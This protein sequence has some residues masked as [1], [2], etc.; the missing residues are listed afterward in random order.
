MAKLWAE[1]QGSGEIRQRKCR[2]VV[3]T[4]SLSDSYRSGHHELMPGCVIQ[5]SEPKERLS[6]TS[7]ISEREGLATTAARPCR[8]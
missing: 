1:R 7:D 6:V 8:S 5:V 4:L 3:E 2:S